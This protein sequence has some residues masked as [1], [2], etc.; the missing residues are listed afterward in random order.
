MTRFR[1][2]RIDFV[3]IAKLSRQQRTTSKIAKTYISHIIDMC[4]ASLSF[5]LDT[6]RKKSIIDMTRKAYGWTGHVWVGKKR[7]QHE[8]TAL[9][10]PRMFIC[11]ALLLRAETCF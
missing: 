1:D 7:D 6:V 9:P 11:V 8:L 5:V 4:G 10:M 3:F 2:Q